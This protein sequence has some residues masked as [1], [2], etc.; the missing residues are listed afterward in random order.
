MFWD[1]VYGGESKMEINSTHIDVFE[2]LQVVNISDNMN[3]STKMLWS[4]MIKP[5]TDAV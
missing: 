4:Q 1:I 2:S 3:I 5:I